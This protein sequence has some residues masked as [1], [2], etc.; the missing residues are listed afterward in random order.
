MEKFLKLAL[1]IFCSITGLLVIVFF[2]LA[3][4]LFFNPTF[5]VN[6]KNINYALKK[7]SLLKTWTWKKGEINHQWISWN[8]RYFSGHFQDLCLI[9]ENKDIAVDTCMEEVSWNLDLKWI[10]GRGFEYTIDRPLIID[11]KK[12]SLTIYDN[13]EDSPSTDYL[14]YWNMLWKKIVPN[15]DFTFREIDIIKPRSH[16]SIDL[17]LIKSPKVLSARSMGYELIGTEKEV[18]IL[19]PHKILLGTDLKTKIPLYFRELKLVGHIT[20]NS[21]PISITGAVETAKLNVETKISTEL[22]KKKINVPEFLKQALLPAHGTLKIEKLKSTLGSILK[23]PYNIL[24]APLNALE[25]SL[26][27][28]VKIEDADGAENVLFKIKTSLDLAG[29][30]QTIILDL[31]TEIPMNLKTKN[32]RSITFGI[33]LKKVALLLPKLAKNK[34]PPQLKPDPRFKLPEVRIANKRRLRKKI[35]FKV[36]LQA[37]GDKALYIKT[38]LLDEVLRLKFDLEIEDGAITKGFIQA[39]PLK[40]TIFRR[41]IIFQSVKIVFNDLFAP[42]LTALIEFHLPEYII[43]LNL[44]GPLSK[45]RQALRSTPPL[46]QDDIYAVL[47]FGQP[48]NGLA[49][50]DKTAAKSAGQILSQGI[51]S[52]AVLYYFSGSPVQSLGYD[53][54]SKVLAAQI[55]LGTK[56]SLRVSSESGGLNTAGVR[57]SLGKGW[58]IDSS[59][60]KTTSGNSGA[61]DYGVLLERIIAY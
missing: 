9:Y 53:P 18:T 10:P 55:G 45:P 22:L 59:V 23:P 1:G 29:A 27:M 40:T 28:D 39:L 44:E 38:N 35:D 30:K 33:D 17:K 24:P 7:T 47:L 19:A 49:T 26:K 52:L 57:R 43:T 60:Q 21:I 20:D 36:H 58:Y 61:T 12:T 46:S 34:M 48:L 50:D 2:S 3:L 31:K 54:E 8:H 41:P 11:S 13:P 4:I 25:G 14:S 15:L 42:E 37:L 32:I 5:I 6:P 51:L 16:F 56:N